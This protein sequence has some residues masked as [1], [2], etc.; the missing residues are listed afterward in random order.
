M[1]VVLCLTTFVVAG[2]GTA[3]APFLLQMTHD[4]SAELAAVANLV[5]IM[6]LAWGLTSLVAGFASDR[7]GRRPVLTGGVLVLSAA[8]IGLALDEAFNFYYEDNLDLLGAWG[9]RLVPFSPLHDV[10]L[11]PDLD[12]LY[13]GGGFPERYADGLAANQASQ[14][15]IR[16]AADAGMPLYA[17]CG[18]LMYLSEGIVDFAQRRH[19]MIGLVPG[20]SAMTRQRLTLGYREVRARCDTPLLS[21]GQT[22]RGHEFHWSVLEAPLLAEHA[23]YDLVA[24]PVPHEG[25]ARGNFLASYCHLHFGSNPSLGPNFIAAAAKWWMQKSVARREGG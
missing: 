13:L 9:A 14:A 11:P 15:A 22:A 6:S 10:A 21:R 3:I 18:G 17:E 23:A 20:W 24:A 4:L 5:A 1:V 2:S 16:A 19:P 12:A 7:V 25:F 8:R